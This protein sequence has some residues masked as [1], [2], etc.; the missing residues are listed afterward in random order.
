[1]DDCNNVHLHLMA[2]E[3]F[4]TLGY[5]FLLMQ[6]KIGPSGQYLHLPFDMSKEGK[7][8]CLSFLFSCRHHPRHRYI[9]KRKIAVHIFLRANNT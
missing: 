2:D 4:S 8:M 1:V 5:V 3:C 6:T 9:N 7:N